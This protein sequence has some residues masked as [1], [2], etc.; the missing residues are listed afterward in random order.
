MVGVFLFAE[1]GVLQNKKGIVKVKSAHTIMKKSARAGYKIKDGDTI[2]TYNSLATIKLNDGSIIKM[3]KFSEIKFKPKNISQN[4]GRAYYKIT[5]QKVKEL[6]VN[7]PYTTIGVKGTVFVVSSKK[8]NNFVALKK[9]KISLTAK[10]GKYAIH[11]TTK[12]EF[13][14]FKKNMMNEFN[15]Y[16]KKLKKEFIEYKKSFDLDAGNMVIFNGNNVY[17]KR[18]DPKVFEYFENEFK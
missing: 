12:D 14:E 16:K 7:T 9:G 17:E 5:H 4:K 1:V 8:A 3:D 13:A 15:D 2:Y 10:K 11:K 18:I 6:A